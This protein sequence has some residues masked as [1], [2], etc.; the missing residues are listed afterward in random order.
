[1]IYGPLKLIRF[2]RLHAAFAR[3]IE[4]EIE[5]VG[6]LRNQIVAEN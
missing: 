3:G 6:L 2:L 5:V 4:A 1:M